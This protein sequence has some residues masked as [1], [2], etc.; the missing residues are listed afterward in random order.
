MN[1]LM[2][3]EMKLNAL[4]VK[5]EMV[6]AVEQYH[7]EDCCYQEGNQPPRRGG[8]AGQKEYLTNFFKTVKSVNALKLHSEAVGDGVT[9]SEWTFDLT[10]ANG[11]ILWNEVHRRLWQ[12]G[13]VVSERYYTAK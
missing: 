11:S 5:G 3:L 4:I 1:D 13:K 9:M 6:E 12:D 10:T 8:K 2:T 7:A